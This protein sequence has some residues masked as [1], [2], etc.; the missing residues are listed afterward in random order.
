MF[1][2]KLSVELGSLNNNLSDA[3]VVYIDVYYPLL[4]LMT[5][6]KKYG[7]IP[8]FFI[9]FLKISKFYIYLGYLI[10]GILQ[11]RFWGCR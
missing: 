3:K 7:N 1:N 11:F 6:P 10:I 5:N 2:D 9:Y 4:D 8:F